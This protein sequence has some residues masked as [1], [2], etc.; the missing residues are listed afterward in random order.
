MD[1][2]F[3]IAGTALRSRLFMGT[4]GYPNRRTLL[5]AL[6]AGGADIVTMSVRRISLDAY[7]ESLVDALGGKYRLLPNTAGCATVRDA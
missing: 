5:A 7:Q 2:E 4:A 6:E 3:E 1:E